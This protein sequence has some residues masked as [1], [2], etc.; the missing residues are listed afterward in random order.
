V[1]EM[2]THLQE[3]EEYLRRMGARLRRLDEQL[4]PRGGRRQGGRQGRGVDHGRVA[5]TWW[6][7]GD[8]AGGRKFDP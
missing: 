3:M 2:Q 6:L 5:L 4:S 7:G 8:I 1:R